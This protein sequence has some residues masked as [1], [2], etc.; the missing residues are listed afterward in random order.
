MGV[1]SPSNESTAY[2]TDKGYGAIDSLLSILFQQIE[3]EKK[4]KIWLRP[5]SSERKF[6]SQSEAIR[7]NA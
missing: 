6:I 7:L 5:L 4:G 3:K 2:S 1:A